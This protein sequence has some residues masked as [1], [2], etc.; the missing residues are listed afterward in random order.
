MK[1]ICA[2]WQIFFFFFFSGKVQNLPILLL[3]L[4]AVC[5]YACVCVWVY[6][7]LQRVTFSFLFSFYVLIFP[8]QRATLIKSELIFHLVLIIQH[9]DLFKTCRSIAGPPEGGMVKQFVS[10]TAVQQRW[11][12][13][14]QLPGEFYSLKGQSSSHRTPTL[15]HFLFSG[16]ELH[17]GPAHLALLQL[18]HPVEPA[19]RPSGS[20]VLSVCEMV[21]VGGG[22]PNL[23]ACI[24]WTLPLKN[25]LSGMQGI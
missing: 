19:P 9:L 4:I 17:L 6:L 12:K 23:K 11:Y 1:S 5:V 14:D 22:Q 18:P 15:C 2:C 25:L 10:V 13:C 8:G 21:L 16:A 20:T 24:L 7:V 3:S